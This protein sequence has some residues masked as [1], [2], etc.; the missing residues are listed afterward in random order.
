[1]AYPHDMIGRSP[2]SCLHTHSGSNMQN[3]IPDFYGE[4]IC[5]S[6]KAPREPW[7]YADDHTLSVAPFSQHQSRSIAR[8]CE[9][10]RYT[11]AKL[12]TDFS[13]MRQKEVFERNC[14]YMILASVVPSAFRTRAIVNIHSSY[15]ERIC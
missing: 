7:T 5:K 11:D 8:G 1:M 4:K 12:P 13:R 15:N 14:V 6:D 9:I 10:A 2:F 3:P